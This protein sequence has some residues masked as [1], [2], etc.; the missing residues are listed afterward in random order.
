MANVD[1]PVVHSSL[2]TTK[3]H[4]AEELDGSKDKQEIRIRKV[5]KQISILKC[6]KVLIS[7][8]KDM[9]KGFV[10]TVEAWITYCELQISAEKKK[11]VAKA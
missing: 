7:W 1:C 2:I 6:M 3:L 10:R 4:E 11:E 9:P 5:Y 8:I